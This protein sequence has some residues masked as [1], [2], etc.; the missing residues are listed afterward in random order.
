M[1]MNLEKPAEQEDFSSNTIESSERVDASK[2]QERRIRLMQHAGHFGND[3]SGAVYQ[4]AT[5]ARDLEEAY[6][7]VHDVYVT[8]GYMTKQQNGLRMRPF[9]F[10]PETATFVAKDML[11]SVI[12]TISVIEDSPDLGLPSD[13]VFKEEIDQI[14]GPNKKICEMS[15]QAV[16]K[17]YQRLGTAG[18][19]MRC[20]GAYAFTSQNTDIICV[21]S[22]HLVALYETLFFEQMGPVK[23]YS[24][25]VEDNVV[26]M[27]MSDIQTR[28]ED[29]RYY[30][31]EAYRKFVD[32]YYNDNPYLAAMKDWNVQ[33]IRMFNEEF[34]IA[35][36][37]GKCPEVVLNHEVS[38]ALHKRLGNIFILSQL[39]ADKSGPPQSEN[40]V[41]QK[42]GGE[43]SCSGK[44]SSPVW[45]HHN[46]RGRSSQVPI[47]A[48]PKAI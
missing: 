46:H 33:N 8:M 30:M 7:V 29:P 28:R 42:T 21:I 17:K 35:G 9:E 44:E 3:R 40:R 18:E 13:C 34:D 11:G 47:S 26:L 41:R 5:N 12:G 1:T 43:P 2:K 10:C 45:E 36:L 22:P 16:L 20:A 25:V 39:A 37:F 6:R 27:R 48:V 31:D 19:L 4:R 23:R 32:C 14:R 38:E 15:N 24:D